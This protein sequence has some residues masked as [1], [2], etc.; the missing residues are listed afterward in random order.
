MTDT[1]V[2]NRALLRTRKLGLFCS[3]HCPGRLVARL[4]DLARA[5]RDARVT[6]VGGFH[7]PMERE[8]LRLILRGSGPAIVCP[9]RN[10]ERLRPPPE[11]KAALEAGTL[12]VVAG[13]RGPPRRVTRELAAQRNEVVASLSEA[14]FVAYAEPGGRTEHIARAAL[15]AGKAVFTF[16][17]PAMAHLREMGAQPI[18]PGWV[19]G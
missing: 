17:D 8:C 10:I 11:W 16:E 19:W 18:G 13:V 3:I 4:Y 7:S 2:G 9:A 6:L 12:L 15:G 5:L 14:L 1:S